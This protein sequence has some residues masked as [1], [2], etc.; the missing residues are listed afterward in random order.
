MKGMQNGQL[1]EE[2]ILFKVQKSPTQYKRGNT[3]VRIGQI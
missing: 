3:E 1:S 2:Q